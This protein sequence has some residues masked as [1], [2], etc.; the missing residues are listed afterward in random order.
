VIWEQVIYYIGFA[1]AIWLCW[2]LGRIFTVPMVLDLFFDAAMS[3]GAFAHG[4]TRWVLAVYGFGVFLW[5][6]ALSGALAKH[7]VVTLLLLEL[8][9]V[10]NGL[11]VP[12]R[13][14]G[15]GAD[16]WD[17]ASSRIVDVWMVSILVVVLSTV[18]KSTVGARLRHMRADLLTNPRKRFLLPIGAWALM[19]LLP[20]YLPPDIAQFLAQDRY[21]IA[22]QLLVWGWVAFELPFYITHRRLMRQYL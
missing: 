10:L 3:L 9:V 19:I 8:G 17:L 6:L 16:F 21:R 2:G 7:M 14:A 5:V 1:A 12:L 20:S 22:G 13:T 4:D 11:W 18:F 15:I